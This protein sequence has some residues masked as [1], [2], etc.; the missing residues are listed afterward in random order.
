MP[1]ESFKTYLQDSRSKMTCLDI[2]SW[3]Q[4]LSFFRNISLNMK[5]GSYSLSTLGWEAMM[6]W[7][8]E[9]PW[10]QPD[11]MRIRFCQVRNI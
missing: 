1:E 11:M 2:G 4:V 8:K 9:D 6:S 7:V 5:S 3:F 10:R